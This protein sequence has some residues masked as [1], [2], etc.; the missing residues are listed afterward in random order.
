MRTDLTP[1]ARRSLGAEAIAALRT[2]EPARHRLLVVAGARDFTARVFDERSV[3][4]GEGFA[5]TAGRAVEAALRS[6]EAVS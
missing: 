5:P 6:V 2:R 3:L 1:M 4:L